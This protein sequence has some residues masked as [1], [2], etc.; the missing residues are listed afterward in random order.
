[1]F[2]KHKRTGLAGRTLQGQGRTALGVGSVRSEGL[3]KDRMGAASRVGRS[4]QQLGNDKHAAAAMKA[5]AG[6]HTN[7]TRE[8]PCPTLTGYQAKPILTA[9]DRETSHGRFVVARRTVKTGEQR[10]A[11]G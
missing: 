10:G 5:E 6:G 9:S 11:R 3:C 1:M 4:P 2:T 7:P 8:T